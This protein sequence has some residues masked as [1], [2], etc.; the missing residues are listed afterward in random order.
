VDASK[1]V[2]PA[3][4][5]ATAKEPPSS[6]EL[7]AAHQPRHCPLRLLLRAEELQHL[8]LVLS[9]LVHD[10]DD[11]PLVSARCQT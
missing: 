11:Q 7:G 5:V 9:A 1:A 8:R 3:S 2:A 10:L 4:I 6:F